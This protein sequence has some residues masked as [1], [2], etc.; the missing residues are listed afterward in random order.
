MV[1]GARG[2]LAACQAK[3]KV[4]SQ[5]SSDSGASGLGAGVHLPSCA[6]DEPVLAQLPHALRTALQSLIGDI[7]GIARAAQPWCGAICKTC[8]ERRRGDGLRLGPHGQDPTIPTWHW[9]TTTTGTRI[10][11]SFPW[12]IGGSLKLFATTPGQTRS[13]FGT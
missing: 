8:A 11:R 4:D 10:E 13:S 6:A 3:S 9:F 12:A 5:D 1:A 2:L 7:Y